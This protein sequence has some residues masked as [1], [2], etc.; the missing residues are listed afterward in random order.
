MD[1][2]TRTT[3]HRILFDRPER[4]TIEESR[5]VSEAVEAVNAASAVWPL[6]TESVHGSRSDAVVGLLFLAMNEGENASVNVQDLV[7]ADKYLQRHYTTDYIGAKRPTYALVTTDKINDRLFIKDKNGEYK[8]GVGTD[9][10]GK[11]VIVKLNVSELP[12]GLTRA[13]QDVYLACGALWLAGNVIVSPSQIA[14]TLGWSHSKIPDIIES[15]DKMR[16]T[17]IDIDNTAE[18][19]A[20][21]RAEY[22]RKTYLLPCEIHHAAFINGRECIDAIMMFS[23]PPMIEYA[24]QT[25]QVQEIQSLAMRTKVSDRNIK[26]RAY[27]RRRVVSKRTANFALWSTIFKET[28]S[29]DPK[30]KGRVKGQILA[31]FQ[32]LQADGTI[33]GYADDER[34]VYWFRNKAAETRY[35]RDHKPKETQI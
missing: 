25:R 26:L 5:L 3:L 24:Q 14:A 22:V 8:I 10:S 4:L 12:S 28:D 23:M 21:G 6:T 17:F 9:K 20:F 27:I 35:F 34:G 29:Y 33:Y 31:V 1:E 16:R 11:R 30:H 15:A 18:H 19:V 2:K 7:E 13:D 32:E